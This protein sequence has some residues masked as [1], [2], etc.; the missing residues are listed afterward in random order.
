MSFSALDPILNTP[1][2]LAIVSILIKLKEA[3]FAY[4]QERTETTQ[5]NLS[6]SLKKLEEEQYI[7]IEKRIN[8]LWNN[9]TLSWSFTNSIRSN[10]FGNY[11]QSDYDENDGYEHKSKD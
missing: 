5:G 1:V 11:E 7:L 9:W 4:L 3:D 10:C 2:R 6:H 8:T